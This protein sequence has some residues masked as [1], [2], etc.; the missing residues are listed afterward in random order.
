MDIFGISVDVLDVMFYFCIVTV[1]Y[2]VILELEFR[3]LRNITRNFD[4][5]ETQ[6]EKEVRELKEEIATLTK[7]IESK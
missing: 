5:E 7:I 2:F 4:N 6:I 3:E 1:A